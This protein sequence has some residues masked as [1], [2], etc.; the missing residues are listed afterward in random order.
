MKTSNIELLLSTKKILFAYKSRLKRTRI[1]VTTLF[2]NIAS[3]GGA[4]HM[5][6]VGNLEGVC[7]C[8]T[9]HVHLR[10]MGGDILH[11]LLVAKARLLSLTNMR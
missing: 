5:L 6:L 2:I 10:S 7:I 4:M 8:V 1:F 9:H 3:M 11:L